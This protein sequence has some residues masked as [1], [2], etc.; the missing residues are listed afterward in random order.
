MSLEREISR[1]AE[2]LLVESKHFNG[3]NIR[4]LTEEELDGCES[5]NISLDY[6]MFVEDIY[7]EIDSKIEEL[8]VET[9]RRKLAR[10]RPDDFTNKE[11]CEAFGFI[12]QQVNDRDR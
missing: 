11:W 10:V 6:G 7:Q 2:R 5:E 1:I 9:I 8:I 4:Q 12:A 3:S